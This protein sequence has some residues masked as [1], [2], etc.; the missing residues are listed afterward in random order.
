MKRLAVTFMLIM[1]CIQSTAWAAGPFSSIPV[2][3][4]TYAAIDKLE[5]AGLID[6]MDNPLNG[7]ILT[8]YE[9]AMLVGK[10][11]ENKSKA[12]PSQK[13]LIEKLVN[14]FAVELKNMGVHTAAI[15]KKEPA[16]ITHGEFDVRSMD[17]RCMGITEAYSQYRLR[18]DQSVKIDDNTSVNWRLKTSPQIAT[19]YYGTSATYK[20]ESS[21]WTTFGSHGNNDTSTK[22]LDMDRVFVSTKVGSVNTKIGAQSLRLG[23]D[24]VI[25]DDAGYNFDGINVV[26]PATYQFPVTLIGNYGRIDKSSTVGIDVNS[27]EA[28]TGSSKMIAGLG[29]A[30]LKNNGSNAANLAKYVYSYTKYLFT[31]HL[32]LSWDYVNNTLYSN[33]NNTNMVFALIGDQLPA[34]SGDNNLWLGYYKVGKNSISRYSILNLT[35]D[36]TG[37]AIGSGCDLRNMDAYGAV[38]TYRFNRTFEGQL[39]YMKIRDKELTTYDLGYRYYRASLT[40]YF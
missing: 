20:Y 32:S 1:I 21:N 38:Y 5:A 36:L 8:R 11:M 26:L 27:I 2:N 33:N 40:A 16:F 37:E 31:P 19:S 28:V 6:G 39:Y 22:T 24:G 13:A 10:A 4:W 14:E 34:K 9:M 3:H 30:T 29:Y 25:Y 23:A 35:Y 17:G 15:D 7:K 18:I 12:T